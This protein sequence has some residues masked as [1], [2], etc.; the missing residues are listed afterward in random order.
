MKNLYWN[1]LQL[2][3]VSAI[4]LSAGGLGAY[5][6][7]STDAAP[8][9]DEQETRTLGRVTVTAQRREEDLLDVP[10]SVTALDS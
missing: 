6:Q 4:A 1:T 5:A 2:G 9:A 10:L 8:A 7:D 3:L